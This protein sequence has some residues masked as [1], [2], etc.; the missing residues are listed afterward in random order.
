MSYLLCLFISLFSAAVRG[1][2]AESALTYASKSSL[3]N[4]SRSSR[5]MIEGFLRISSLESL[6]LEDWVREGPG[7]GCCAAGGTT[8]RSDCS[9]VLRSTLEKSDKSST[10]VLSLKEKSC[11]KS[12]TCSWLI[13]SSP[14]LM[15]SSA[16]VEGT[17][18]KS[19]SNMAVAIG[20]CV[21]GW[22]VGV[23]GREIGN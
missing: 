3:V 10:P 4:F 12:S 9:S 21:A 2:V 11:G 20:K 17:W 8:S 22:G 19:S 15:G 13:Q 16:N 1:R 18:A 23:K 14:P 7:A 5:E 6:I